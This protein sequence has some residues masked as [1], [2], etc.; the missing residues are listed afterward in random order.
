MAQVMVHVLMQ[1]G[2]NLTRE[3]IMHQATAVK[4]L[5]LTASIKVKTGLELFVREVCPV[6]KFS[7]ERWEA[8]GPSSH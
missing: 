4:G 7:G 3:N 6:A 1:A 5:M 2:N 8:F